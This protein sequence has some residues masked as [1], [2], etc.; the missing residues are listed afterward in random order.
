MLD[1]TSYLHRQE[2]TEILSRWMVDHPEPG[3]VRRLKTI[4]NF[5][6]YGARL[7]IDRLVRDLIT[8]LHG[9][10]P[11]SVVLRT[12]GQLKDFSADHLPFTNPNIERMVAHYRRF[13]ED[14]YRETPVDGVYYTLQ[15]A[16]G[17]PWLAGLSRIKRFRR[18]AEKGS[19]RIVDFMLARIR[20]AAE[21]LA[22]ERA[23]RLGIPAHLLVTGPE[24]MAAEFAHAERRVIKSIKQGTIREA[25]PALEIPDAVGMKLILE[26]DR[27]EELLGLLEAHP[28]CTLTEVEEHT[29]AYAATNL[30]V[31]LELPFEL[32]RAH[33]PT[34]RYLQVL[35]SRGFDP[36]AVPG[37]WARFL[38]ES[39]GR[40]SFEIIVAGFEA[41]LES[42]IGQTMHEA[43]ILSQRASP[44]YHGPLATNVRY[45]V[46]YVFALCRA[47][48]MEDYESLPIKLWSRYMPDTVGYLV[49]ALTVSEDL[50]F[51]AAPEVEAIGVAA[52]EP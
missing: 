11:A 40:A 6:V 44:D 29:G 52:G 5:N 1:I 35:V 51:D 19:R 3:D 38:E 30:H 24:Q 43:R 15:R 22:S 14:Y 33:P 48:R 37:E 49:R 23:A 8:G 16:G 41:Y 20:T 45:L 10:A 31:S 46:N 17:E 39:E 2:L 7:W 12:K 47:P 9:E 27:L 25:L 42:E 13:P 21:E 4:V 32:L 34:G 36:A 18:I 26:R 28:A 50:S